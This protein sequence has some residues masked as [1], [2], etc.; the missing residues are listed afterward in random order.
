[1]DFFWRYVQDIMH[2]DRV[3]SVP[4]LHPVIVVAIAVVPVDVFPQL[5]VEVEFHFNVCRAVIGAHIELH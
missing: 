1:M 3:K 4:Y 2:S 5:W